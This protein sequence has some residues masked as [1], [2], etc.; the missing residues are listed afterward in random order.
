VGDAD[1]GGGG[2][3]AVLERQ[4]EHAQF[5]LKVW[6]QGLGQF[7]DRALVDLGQAFAAGFIEVGALDLVEELLDH[8]PDAHHL[9]RGGHRLGQRFVFAY[10]G[11]DLAVLDRNSRFNRNRRFIGRRSRVRLVVSVIRGLLSGGGRG[12]EQGYEHFGAG[13][14]AMATDEFEWTRVG[15]I[16]ERDRLACHE[17]DIAQPAGHGRRDSRSE[18]AFVDHLLAGHHPGLLSVAVATGREQVLLG[19]GRAWSQRKRPSPDCVRTIASSPLAGRT[20]LSPTCT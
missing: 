19:T 8:R 18:P 9:G 7:H 13:E 1:L 15:S 12:R 4:G 14:A 3:H 17:G 11:H 2:R 20:M 6:R 5:L 10:C 16:V